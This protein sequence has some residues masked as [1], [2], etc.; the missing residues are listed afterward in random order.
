[1]NKRDII[2]YILVIILS[3]AVSHIYTLNNY[4]N[5]YK[6]Q[7]RSSQMGIE[8]TDFE[9]SAKESNLSMFNPSFYVD[10]TING[11]TERITEC[12]DYVHKSERIEVIDGKETLVIEFKP[13]FKPTINPFKFNV[14]N[15][16]SKTFKYKVYGYN[17]GDLIYLFKCGDFEQIIYA[18]RN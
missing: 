15:T 5:D 6:I 4:V 8:I 9:V 17:S 11:T 18:N 7:W 3:F 2:K 13:W 12:I 16:F 1:M 10:V 14:D